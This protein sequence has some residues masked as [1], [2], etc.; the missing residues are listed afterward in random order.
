MRKNEP[1]LDKLLNFMVSVNN[2]KSVDRTGWIINGITQKPEHVADHSFS[3]ALLSYVLAEHLKLDANKCLILGLMH[4]INEAVTGDIA[5]RPNEKD[6]THNNKE[7]HKL[8]HNNTLKLLSVLDK[9]DKGMFMKLWKEMQEQKSKEAKLV[10]EIDALDYIIQ[11]ISYSKFVK[12]PE[13]FREFFITANKRISTPEV[14][15]LFD[16]IKRQILKD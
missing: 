16:K 7:K 4:D 15:Y 6:Q 1:Y 13:R 12:N 14:V 5:T 3:T 10:K 2:L 8:E 11:T 9:T